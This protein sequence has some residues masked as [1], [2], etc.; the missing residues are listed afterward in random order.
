MEVDRG[1][2]EARCGGDEAGLDLA[3]APALADD[4]V[5]QDAALGAAVEGGDRLQPRPVAD[6]VAGGVAGLG[7]EL[8]VVDVDDQVPAAAGVEA[9][10]RA[11]R[12]SSPKEYSSLLR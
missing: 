7:G 10:D 3:G 6:R 12:R 8:A 11:R 2:R 1:P 4:E 5:A 9:E